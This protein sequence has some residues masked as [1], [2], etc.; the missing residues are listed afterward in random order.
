MLNE[1]IR[2]QPTS[3]SAKPFANGNAFEGTQAVTSKQV[4][5]RSKS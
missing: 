2:I 3:G 5:T 1:L 4:L